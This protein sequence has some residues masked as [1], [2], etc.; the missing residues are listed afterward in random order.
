MGISYY[1]IGLGSFQKVIRVESGPECD[2]SSVGNHFEE[3]FRS[4]PPL[5]GYFMM[6]IF[7]VDGLSFKFGMV[8]FPLFLL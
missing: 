3:L 4:T 6:T 8:V 2:S 7:R 5:A 1:S